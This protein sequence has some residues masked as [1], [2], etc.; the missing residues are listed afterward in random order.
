MSMKSFDVK[1]MPPH[2][3]KE[4]LKMVFNLKATP[5]EMGALVAMFDG[6]VACTIS[7]SDA[8]CMTTLPIHAS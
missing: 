7:L 3:F 6:M 8:M 4:Q 1:D 5:A 2:V